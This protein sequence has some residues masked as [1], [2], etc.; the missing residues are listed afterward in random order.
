MTGAKAP[1]VWFI[2][3]HGEGRV[4]TLLQQVQYAD[5]VEAV[6]MNAEHAAVLCQGT[7]KR[8]PQGGAS[9]CAS[10]LPCL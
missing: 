1:Q 4:A 2:E 9:G 6:T 5:A 8:K 7:R 3:L 10:T